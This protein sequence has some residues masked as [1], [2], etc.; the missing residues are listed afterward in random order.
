MKYGRVSAGALSVI[1]ALKKFYGTDI[2][3][4]RVNRH[5]KTG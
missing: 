2:E 4:Y 3:V 1:A 5:P